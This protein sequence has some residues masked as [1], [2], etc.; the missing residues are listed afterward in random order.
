MI[1]GFPLYAQDQDVWQPCQLFKSPV[2]EKTAK[3]GSANL[4]IGVYIAGQ[5]SQL[6]ETTILVQVTSSSTLSRMSSK[7]GP[8]F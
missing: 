2:I 8:S 4:L 5:W 7:V 1:Q 3:V 6:F